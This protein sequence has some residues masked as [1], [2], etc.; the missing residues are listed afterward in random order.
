MARCLWFSKSAEEWRQNYLRLQ[1]QNPK[2]G[3]TLHQCL[4]NPMVFHRFP[5]LLDSKLGL[6]VVLY[7]VTIMVLQHR[8]RSVALQGPGHEA[9]SAPSAD[10]YI[11]RLMEELRVLCEAEWLKP[12][13]AS[14]LILEL[15]AMYLYAPVFHLE[16][17]SSGEPR[18]SSPQI[19]CML[20][21][22]RQTRTVRRAVW[23]AGQIIRAA[24]S[25][26]SDELAD[27]HVVAVY[28]A[29]VCLWM[30]AS[31][32]NTATPP[33]GT[34][35]SDFRGELIHVNGPE[36]LQT[37]KWISHGCG[38][39]VIADL[40]QS[41]SALHY[42]VELQPDLSPRGSFLRSIMGTVY[43]I[44]PRHGAGLPIWKHVRRILCALGGP[45]L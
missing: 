6:S 30:Y 21:D 5:A 33:A 42:L 26:T 39:P 36:S 43:R 32:P 3:I 22:W 11:L 4:A 35:V 16:D 44:F 17:I 29:A 20:R 19:A 25:L 28:Q 27:F 24:T 34:C 7:S 15:N 18:R 14:R 45:E 10:E 12:P 13:S 41:S 38:V 1:A 2:S 8:Q 31:S 23:H 37:Q 9:G 40:D